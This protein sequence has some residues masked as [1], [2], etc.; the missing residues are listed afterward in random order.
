MPGVHVEQL[1]R[2]RVQDAHEQR[3]VNRS[4]RVALDVDVNLPR[5]RVE[6]LTEREPRAQRRLD[7]RHEE[8]GTH[9]LARH[10]ADEQRNPPV[11]Q[12]EVVEEIAADFLGRHRH[13]L[14]LGQPEPERA[15]RQ[16]VVLDLAAELELA[17]DPFLLHRRALVKLD[18]FG[19]LIERLG[20][21]ADLVVGSDLDARAVVAERDAPY[22]LAERRQ[23]LREPR[24]DRYH[25]DE[26]EADEAQ[27]ESGIAR[28]RPPQ[29]LQ[30]ICDRARDAKPQPRSGRIGRG[31]DDPVAHSGRAGRR[32][33]L[34]HAAANRFELLLVV[35]GLRVE[36]PVF[37]DRKGNLASIAPRRR[38][39]RREQV[40]QVDF[41]VRGAHH[42]AVALEGDVETRARECRLSPRGSRADRSDRSSGAH[43]GSAGGGLD[44]GDRRLRFRVRD[45]LRLGDAFLR[46]GRAELNS[47]RDAEHALVDFGHDPLAFD[48][49]ELFP[50]PFRHELTH[51]VAPHRSDVNRDAV[52]WR[53]V[54]IER[55]FSARREPAIGERRR[56]N[57]GRRSDTGR[58]RRA[59]S[60]VNRRAVGRRTTARTSRLR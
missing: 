59:R 48:L 6:I 43:G 38:Q 7:V 4:G 50:L 14:D 11:A 44:R 2:C 47:L 3:R 34:R 52:A 30:R 8:R 45:A 33:G 60:R 31:H 46:L 15:L 22:T 53:G 36:A 32:I 21:P 28:A 57:H 12:R 9:A 19:H 35:S 55:G 51:D 17:L 20:E 56:W 1:P 29:R 54:R 41:G 23:I 18:V 26:C 49:G 39:H 42:L 24:G 10:V 58:W 5:D 40:R 37:S 27:A 16:H 25:H 13:A